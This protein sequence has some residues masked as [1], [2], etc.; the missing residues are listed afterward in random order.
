MILKSYINNFMV[1]GPSEIP[2][3]IFL[4]FFPSKT[5]QKNLDP[6]Y[7]MDPDF[8]GLFRKGKTCIIAKLHRTD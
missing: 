8:L 4:R 1:S 7:K 3:T 6:S 5:I 2:P